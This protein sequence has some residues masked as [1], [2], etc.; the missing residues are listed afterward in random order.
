MGLSEVVPSSSSSCTYTHQ[1]HILY[2]I[3]RLDAEMT[4][5][6]LILNVVKQD[7]TAQELNDG[8]QDPIFEDD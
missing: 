2:N 8:K 3:W 5:H 1:F 6:R 4:I 7:P